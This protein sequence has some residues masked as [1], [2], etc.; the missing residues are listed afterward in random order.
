MLDGIALAS[1]FPESAFHTRGS[2]HPITPKV[3]R[4]RGFDDRAR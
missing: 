4:E 1:L 2:D 3:V